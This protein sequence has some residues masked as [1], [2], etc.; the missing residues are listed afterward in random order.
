MKQPQLAVADRR[1]TVKFNYLII[2]CAETIA[3]GIATYLREL[4][5]LQLSEFGPGRIAVIVP[6]SQRLHL[7]APEDVDVFYFC[8]EDSRPRRALR[9]ARF[10]AAIARFSR[11]AVLHVHSTFAGATVRPLLRLTIPSVKIVY[12]PHGWAFDRPSSHLGALLIQATELLLSPF[13][14]SIV[15]VS[16]HEFATA[17]RKGLSPS[18][19]RLVINGISSERPAG[20]GINLEWP[21]GKLRVL[22]VGRLDKQKGADV[23]VEAMRRMQGHASGL[24][25]GVPVLKDG[26]NLAL[27]LPSNVRALG[28]LSPSELEDVFDSAHILVVPSRW[29]GFGLVAA[30]GM[31]AGLPVIATRVGGLQEIVQDGETGVLIR[32]ES[33]GE[34]ISAL[35]KT[36]GSLLY[37]M[38]SAAQNRVRQRFNIERVHSELRDIYDTVSGPDSE[39]SILA[40]ERVA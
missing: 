15:C 27:T 6:Y 14:H 17:V 16:R 13:C 24:M 20:A 34:L 8:D 19:L 31:R 7:T 11:N 2:H 4:L 21:N 35:R 5:P 26:G 36:N 33:V 3:G 39:F 12:C 1:S 18:R 37:R 40:Q 32:S 25:V 29:E 22:F 10:T 38:G 23:Y 28:W 30:E 9:L